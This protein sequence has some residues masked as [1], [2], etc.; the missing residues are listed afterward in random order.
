M[1]KATSM[2][3]EHT[4]K[5]HKLL[6]AMIGLQSQQFEDHSLMKSDVKAV[7]LLDMDN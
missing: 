6:L 1:E 5:L 3:T 7:K 2:K 4:R